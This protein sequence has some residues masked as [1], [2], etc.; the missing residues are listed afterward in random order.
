L[1][2]NFHS[3]LMNRS[4]LMKVVTNR[5]SYGELM[6]DAMIDSPRK[7]TNSLGDIIQRCC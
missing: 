5:A 4:V 2:F 7:S 6:W 1:K 3:C